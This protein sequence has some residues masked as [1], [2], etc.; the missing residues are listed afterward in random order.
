MVSWDNFYGGLLGLSFVFWGLGECLQKGFYLNIEKITLFWGIFVM[1]FGFACIDESLGRLR[2][3]ERIA[4]NLKKIL[5][6]KS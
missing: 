1:M 2:F 6:R 4:K 3:Q 5:K